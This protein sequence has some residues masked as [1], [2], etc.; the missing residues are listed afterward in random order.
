[1]QRCRQQWGTGA[2]R[3]ACVIL[4]KVDFGKATWRPSLKRRALRVF[5]QARLLG[6]WDI[7]QERHLSQED[8]AQLS[9]LNQT[10]ISQLERGQRV[11]RRRTIQKLAAALSVRPEELT[12]PAGSV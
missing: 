1:M 9:G 6:L 11:A 5:N 12:E 8:L 10:T 2:D 4:M 3:A 7:R